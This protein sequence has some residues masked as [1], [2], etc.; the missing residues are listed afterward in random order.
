VEEL[1]FA[2]E[3]NKNEALTEKT[4]RLDTL[5]IDYFLFAV[6]L[7]DMALRESLKWNS[8]AISPINREKK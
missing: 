5:R 4:R 6:K 3:Y 7:W 1:L 8:N 2:Q